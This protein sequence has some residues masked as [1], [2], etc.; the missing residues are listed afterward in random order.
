[1]YSAH[2]IFNVPATF[3]LSFF[4]KD[5]Q[6]EPQQP[7]TQVQIKKWHFKQHYISQ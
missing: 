6:Y 1:M 7:R 2:A 3:F 5:P 4:H